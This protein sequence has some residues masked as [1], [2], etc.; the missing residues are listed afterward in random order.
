MKIFKKIKSGAVR[1]KKWFLKLS[2]VK[3][4][5]TVILVLGVV[6]FAFNRIGNTNNQPE[7]LFQKVERSNIEQIVSETGNVNSSGIVDVYSSSTGIME[8]V[9]IENGAEV[10]AGQNLFK[11][12]STATDQ[13]KATAFATYQSASSAYNQ[14]LNTYRDREATA[15]KVEDDVKDH[16]SDETFA[17]KAART[18]AQAAR[19]SAYDAIAAA[20]ASLKSAELAYY[21][22]QNIIVRAPASGTVANFLSKV[23]DH[24]T[25][26]NNTSGGMTVLS[27]G[28]FSSYT[29]TLEL[30]EV[31]IPKV[32]VGQ[33]A[34]FTLDAFPRKKFQGKVTHVDTIGT[35]VS[36]VI[37]YTVVVEIIDPKDSIRPT[38]TANVDIVVDKAENTLTVPNSAIKP[39]QGGKAV[40]LI[41]PQTNSPKYI[42]VEVGIKSSERT[43]IVSG[44]KEGK[45]IITGAKNGVVEANG[46]GPFGR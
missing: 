22:T 33:P 3:K 45:E 10:K 25:A 20:E 46:G 6:Y 28:D 5:F 37:T 4:I 18:T 26:G 44:I 32:K 15:Q 24:V 23:G 21:A 8:A 14:A 36:G 2:L 16:D 34:T 19:D 31:D 35:N 40:Q 12:R 29:V 27:I 30:N 42:P 9:Y 1:V 38:M 11:V 17:Q 39:Y 41:D 7:Y 43:Q 13:E